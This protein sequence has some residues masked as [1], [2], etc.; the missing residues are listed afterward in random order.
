MAVHL[1]L[2]EACLTAH[3]NEQQTQSAGTLLLG[4]TNVVADRIRELSGLGEEHHAAERLSVLRPSFSTV[5][6]LRHPEV[7]SMLDSG[8]AATV[9]NRL[10]AQSAPCTARIT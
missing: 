5:K 1:G 8:G 3:P 10:L 7:L 6:I 2:K 9:R 4:N